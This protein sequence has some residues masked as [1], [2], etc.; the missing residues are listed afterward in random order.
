[1]KAQ[2]SLAALLPFALLVAASCSSSSGGS[3]GGIASSASS[4]LPCAVDDVL[5]RNCRSCHSSPPKFG[6]PM[7]LATLADVRAA[8]PSQAG[9]PVATRIGERIHDPVAPMPQGGQ[10]DAADLATLDTWIA[11]GAP[12]AEAS[13]TCAD[14]GTPGS[15][16]G[17]IGPDALPC[18]PGERTTFVAHG[19]TAATAPYALAADAGNLYM[20]FT[21][22]A[23]WTTTTQATSF[24]PI[25]DDARVVH[26]WIL[27]ETASPQTEGGV[28]PCQMPFDAKFV[29]G[30][31]PG[32]GNTALPDDI[33]LGLP[34][35]ERW[36]ILQ[37][38]YWNVAGYTDVHDRS[39][40]AMCTTTALRPKTAVVSTL[41]SANID[42]PPRSS[43]KVV[44]GKCTPQI[45]EPI[46]VLSANPHM[47]GRGR[48]LK[49]EVLRG[50]SAATVDTL[51][52][53]P[54]FDFQFQ[55]AHASELIINPGDTLTT[56]CTYDN[57]TDKRVN[58]GE[59]TEDEM[60]FDFVM[61]W[62]APGL[63]N[64]GGKASQRCIDP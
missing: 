1:M 39:G 45:T 64:S 27:Y 10:L 51:V 20:C 2:L 43:G 54:A 19:A 34:T 24:A 62:P 37:V 59:K 50:G 14:A 21:W 13:A 40:V 53:E 12:A 52:D 47:H 38:H 17:A 36:L 48:K 41:G 6:A 15:D 58:F 25:I 63:F 61:V 29:Q 9:K 35:A 56:S 33:G 3:A 57:P 23:P 26:H 18:P 4:A 31:A 5:A 60:C 22:K 30:W 32:G 11:A 55:R 49:T 42:L 44:T 16:A 7:P 8:S 46:H 28:A